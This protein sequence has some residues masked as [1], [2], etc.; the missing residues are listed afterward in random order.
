MDAQKSAGC[1]RA[2]QMS[3]HESVQ[4]AQPDFSLIRKR[5]QEREISA[6]MKFSSVMQK[7]NLEFLTQKIS[8]SF[9]LASDIWISLCFECAYTNDCKWT[10]SS[11]IESSYCQSIF[12][13]S[14]WICVLWERRFRFNRMR[15]RRVGLKM[16]IEFENCE[17]SGWI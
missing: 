8:S 10:D 14:Q 11:L 13:Q 6:V 7:R 9:V 16:K 2:G 15:M 12:F 4:K 5:T 1:S 3:S 17:I